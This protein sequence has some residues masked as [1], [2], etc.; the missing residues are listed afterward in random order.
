MT[1]II[2]NKPVGP[3][4]ADYSNYI[5]AGGGLS[6]MEFLLLFT[7]LCGAVPGESQSN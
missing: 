7:L 3:G 5:S 6:I 1:I 4:L 2:A